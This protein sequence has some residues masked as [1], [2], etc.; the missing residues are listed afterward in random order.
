METIGTRELKQNPQTV[1]QRVLESGDEFEI[2][3]YGR[4]TGVRLVP[5]HAQKRRWVSGAEL[6]TITS[7][8]PLSPR[9]AASWREDVENAMDD[10]LVDPWEQT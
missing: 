6:M 3:A 1:I 8:S 10:E 4:P 2:T 5:D 9:D 7:A